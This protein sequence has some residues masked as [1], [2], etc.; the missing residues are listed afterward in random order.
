MRLLDSPIE[1]QP[2]HECSEFVTALIM[3]GYMRRN[4][5]KA[6][7]FSNDDRVFHK[8]VKYRIPLSFF[9]ENFRNTSKLEEF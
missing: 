2:F 7:I 8:E 5:Y 4:I 1:Q 9:L 3:Q 6:T